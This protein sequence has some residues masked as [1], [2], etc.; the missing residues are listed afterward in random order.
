MSTI[1]LGYA[2]D[3]PAPV[4][5]PLRKLFNQLWQR[6]AAPE[7]GRDADPDNPRKARDPVAAR[8]PRD[9]R[10]EAILTAAE[11]AVAR[12]DWKSAVERLQ[13]LLDLPDDA[14]LLTKN[15]HGESLRTAAHR[16]LSGAPATVL[17][18]YER[19][20][21]GLA[22][23]L[24]DDARRT[25]SVT[26]L[27]NVATRFPATQAGLEAARLLD[28]WHFD[29]SE[30]ALAY[31]GYRGDWDRNGVPATDAVW[32]LQAAY[33]ALRVG[34]PESQL[35]WLSGVTDA[36][37]PRTVH[38]AGSDVAATAWWQD[39]LNAAAI[40]TAPLTDWRQLGGSAARNGLGTSGAPL[41]LPTWSLPLTKSAAIQSALTTL[42]ADLA[43]SQTVTIPAASPVIVGNRVAFRDLRGV[44]V[45]DLSTGKTAWETSE[46]ISPER[47]L[48]GAAL[49]ELAD[50]DAFQ[51][52]ANA[53]QMNEEYLGESAQNHPLASWLYRD[54]TS[55]LI[56]SDG[57]RLF[58]LEDVAVL[59]RNQ[60]GYQ[61]EGE[62]TPADP[63]GA[64]WATN[65]LSAYDLQTGRLQ[66]TVGGPHSG[67]MQEIPLA[68]AFF[69]GVPVVDAGEMYA[70][71]TQGEEI[72]LHAL[73][74]DTG[75]P[76][77][78]QLLAY[79]DTKIDLDLVRRWIGAP[80][81]VGQ[82]I[83]ICPTAAGWLVAVDRL[84]RQLVWACRYAPKL[85]DDQE[86]DPAA[87]FLPQQDL[88]DAWA[89]GAPIVQGARVIF[90]PPD[91]DALFCVHLVDG[92]IVW[93]HPRDDG[94]YVATVQSDRVVVVGKSQV[95]ALAL[96]DGSELWETKGPPDARPTGRA[97]VLG[98]QIAVPYSDHQVWLLDLADGQ[99][100]SRLRT[101]V[102]QPP[103][104]NLVKVRD[105]LV[106]LGAHG[107]RMFSERSRSLAEIAERQAR[108]P[109]DP[110]AVLQQGELL[111]LDQKWNEAVALLKR[112][113][114]AS[115]SDEQLNQ[116]WN[117]LWRSMS[118][119]IHADLTGGEAA[120]AE[121]AAMAKTDAQRWLIATRQVDRD[122]A[123]K[124]FDKAFERLWAMTRQPG[125]DRVTPA[126]DP[127]LSVQREAWLRG[128]LSDVWTQ[129]PPELRSRIDRQ[130]QQLIAKTLAGP[131]DDW[132]ALGRWRDFHPAAARLAWGFAEQ[133]TKT[134][135]FAKAESALASWVQHADIAVATESRVRL[136]RVWQQFGL[137]D[138]A[139]SLL[140]GLSARVMAMRLS[141][142]DTVAERIALWQLPH[143]IAAAVSAD[144]VVR[145]R[146]PLVPQRTT[147]SYA[148]PV[149]SIAPDEP[150]PYFQRVAVQIDAQE[151]RL[152]VQDRA[153]GRWQWLAPL[154]TGAQSEDTGSSPT[155]FVGHR[156]LVLHRG[157]L[158]MASPVE[159]RMLW[160]RPLDKSDAHGEPAGTARLPQMLVDPHEDHFG[161]FG[162]TAPGMAGGPIAVA[163]EHIVVIAGSRSL[164]AYDPQSGRELWR[165]DGLPPYAA[166]FGS[167][168]L[169]FVVDQSASTAQAF[170]D[171]DGQAVAV[172]KLDELLARTLVF[173]GRDVVSLEAGKGLRLFNLTTGKTVL[174]RF[175]PLTS[176]ERWQV[177]F[178]PRTSV[179]LLTPGLAIAVEPA[180]NKRNPGRAVTLVDL[181]TGAQRPL[182]ALHSDV[183]DGNLFAFCDAD[184]VYLTVVAGSAG[185]YHYGDSLAT[186]DITGDLCVWDRQTGDRLWQ[187][188]V[189]ELNL[190]F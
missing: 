151:Q 97:A 32:R 48:N 166:V 43:G 75:R 115:W 176:I 87:Q 11:E 174:R 35:A 52:R 51:L 167:S 73:D 112:H 21:G 16:V 173:R 136:A 45:V 139:A 50:G 125:P 170:R 27:V 82:G 154:R 117:T 98:P 42:L 58:V 108:S 147:T 189:E 13:T 179:G 99:I 64:N 81:T 149:Q 111:L 144:D 146:W 101:P 26:G 160:T 177:A 114:S 62:S 143:E 138:D 156:I 124:Q 162:M 119:L 74:P 33:A 94:A 190:V 130:M 57:R 184:R 77:W 71:A 49:D 4:E 89:V 1:S 135:E 2:D 137:T 46:G 132:M 69:L 148:A 100:T 161:E 63:F 28:A 93:Q 90:A 172:P 116:R 121:L 171:Y 53:R 163:N 25:A 40:P 169:V 96:A 34:E 15:G 134:R 91:A 70:V 59:T 14:L 41:L 145:R 103:L 29:H 66:W 20:Y 23:Q 182:A 126:D 123:L 88:G 68:G 188:T 80:V 122:L 92:R 95:T 18:D 6:G 84:R 17:S 79:A 39:H 178:K 85:D 76:R 165:R 8:A 19:Q 127:T 152:T 44:R 105:R 158:Q 187:R 104:E 86:F 153:T 60:A 31:R 186:L 55:G 61:W 159:K 155:E 12:K 72:R 150:L 118:E 37:V 65:R 180:E 102:D 83:V 183:G 9:P 113:N 36:A 38:I 22:R 30:F 120:L 131:I 164:T 181:D 129:A 185:G 168:E 54:A 133:W 24:F 141:T 109:N 10:L 67:E 110:V 128:R 56:S 78:S 175:D 5:P 3:P 47:I 107:C 157:V 106:S 7:P 142:G 140:A